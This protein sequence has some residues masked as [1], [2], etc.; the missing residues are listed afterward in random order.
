M[1]APGMF[2]SRPGFPR[3]L[4]VLLVDGDESKRAVVQ[5]QLEGLGYHVTPC[6]EAAEAAALLSACSSTMPATDNDPVQGPQH[7]EHVLAHRPES[8]H[9]SCVGG[10][11]APALFD[12]VL[13]DVCASACAAANDGLAAAAELLAVAANAA[14]VALVLMGER[15]TASQIMAGVKAGAADVLERPLGVMKLKTLWQHTVR[16]EME[17]RGIGTCSRRR[18][19]ARRRGAGPG[20]AAAEPPLLLPAVQQEQEPDHQ[21]GQGQQPPL[22]QQQ[23]QASVP[24]GPCSPR[25]CR[26]A[27]CFEEDDLAAFMLAQLSDAGADL[28]AAAELV[29]AGM[30]AGGQH[31]DGGHDD[32][33]HMRDAGAA[34]AGDLMERGARPAAGRAPLAPLRIRASPAA[35]GGMS[36]I[37]PSLCAATGSASDASCGTTFSAGATCAWQPSPPQQC[38]AP[39]APAPAAA[40]PAF[41]APSG[42]PGMCQ[43]PNV[44]MTAAATCG[45]PACPPWAYHRPPMM[46]CAGLPA[47]GGGAGMVWG[48]PMASVVT[49]PGTVPGASPGH[50]LARQRGPPGRQP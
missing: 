35:H 15:C 17:R 6:A 45:V 44:A 22:H 1:A 14:D 43:P 4:R 12:L 28:D 29:G 2:A 50:P 19:A 27:A 47:P 30:A 10:S 49:A 5:G 37:S 7:H 8:S 31:D 48:M 26:L 21:Q 16:R 23:Q 24:V 39:S 20:A 41:G 3:G 40:G 32:G 25:G 18:L 34:A 13:A 42:P 38:G 46:M 36:P 11:D 33:E 9:D